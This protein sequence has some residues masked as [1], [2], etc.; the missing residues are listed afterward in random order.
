MALFATTVMN[1]GGVKKALWKE[2]GSHPI[3][4]WFHLLVTAVGIA[5]LAALLS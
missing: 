2:L 5:T 3:S 1:R 4:T